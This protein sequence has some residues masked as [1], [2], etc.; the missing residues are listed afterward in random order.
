M[1][2]Q[3]GPQDPG[4]P[5]GDSG[6]DD[7]AGRDPDSTQHKSSGAGGSDG[8]NPRD[9]GDRP[10]EPK[11]FRPGLI[12]IVIAIGLAIALN[13]LIP[14]GVELSYDEFLWHADKGYVTWIQLGDE[15]HYGEMVLP[16]DAEPPPDRNFRKAHP[17]EAGKKKEN[18]PFGARVLKYW[19]PDQRGKKRRFDFRVNKVRDDDLIVEKLYAAGTKFKK[20]PS[21][22][23]WLLYLIPFGVVI[24]FWFLLMRQSGQMGRAAMSFGRSR[25]KLHGDMQNVDF[26]DVAGCDE[27][28]VELSEIADFLKSP[29]KYQSLGGRMPKGILLVGPP[30]TGK[31]LL[32]R[33][34]AG[35]SQVPFFTL[36]G[37]DFVEMFVGVGAARVRDLFSQAKQRAPCIV[38]VDELDAVGR[39][40][41]AGLG[42][43]HDEREQTL[44]Q[45]LVEMD[46]FDAT[47]GVIF[48]AATNRPDVLDPALLRPGRFDRQVV[49]DAPDAKGRRAILE[50]HAREKPFADGL[51]FENLAVSTPGFTGADL[52]NV[53]NEAALL[54]ARQGKE[55]I[56]QTD[57]QEAVDRVIAGPE[58]KSRRLNEDERKRVAY[59]EAGH[60]L[61]AAL[62]DHSDPVRKISIIPRG[63][64]ALGYTMQTP[65][66]DRYLT[67]KSNLLDQLRSLLAGR[68][69]E[70][71]VFDEQST[72]AANDLERATRLARSM[73]CRFGMSERIGPV[74]F[75]REQTQVFLGRDFTQEDRDYSEL[76][77][78]QID[79]EVRTLL[80]ESANFA[81][82]LLTDHRD[83]L[84][85]VTQTLLEKE[86]IQGKELDELLSC[87]LPK[88]N[89]SDSEANTGGEATPDGEANPEGNESAP[90]DSAS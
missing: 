55:T 67:T 35:E 56:S 72:G 1:N 69:A 81:L 6:R 41:G 63:H 42:G 21:I 47:K 87:G 11:K 22:G 64:A 68:A 50:V 13:A 29:K 86:V 76:S 82:K 58:R 23:L 52:A 74:A 17:Q 37:S 36:S 59:H 38:F 89:G 28:K 53:I 18:P 39:Q 5:G 10:D 12:Y 85:N 61:V 19:E 26:N 88:K 75:G 15:H 78:Q 70:I 32:A 46:G 20:K 48:L 4:K 3:S 71:L 79:T 65:E 8:A 62:S 49:I 25:A 7:S 45:L 34:V 60:A 2:D 51:D 14:S 24:A 80:E 73:V 9:A 43:G 27:A 30:G 90:D 57:L 66:Y 44:N 84:E 77:A 16:P 83:C 54:A 31:T 33:A 40:R